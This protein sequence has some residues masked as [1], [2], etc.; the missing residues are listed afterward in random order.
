M[1]HLLFLL[2]FFLAV[3]M[4]FS[5]DG[6]GNIFESEITADESKNN[7]IF[8]GEIGFN[9][10]SYLDDAWDSDKIILPYQ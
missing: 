10:K 4:T 9:Y 1:K 2:I 8:N 3:G 5:Q 6:F 7:V